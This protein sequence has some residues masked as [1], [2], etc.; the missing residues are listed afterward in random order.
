MGRNVGQGTTRTGIL[1]AL[2]CYAMWGVLPL[3]WKLLSG[4][5]SLEVVS[6]RIIWCCAFTII[7]C[8][9]LKYDFVSL[10]KERRAR[11][12]LI[13]AAILI[14]LNWSI[15]II[16]V[17]TDHIVETA[18]GYY[19]NPLVSIVLGVIVFRERLSPLQIVAV[20]LCT[21]GII[22]FTVGYGQMPLIA[23]ALA[24]T[25]GVYGA[26]KKKGGYPAVEALAF[27]NLVV[28]IPA[29]LVAIGTAFV[30]G[31]HGFLG[32]VASLEGCKITLLLVLG[33][34]VT[35]L[36]LILFALA[37]NLVPLSILGFIQ[38]LS[39]TLALLI[40][41]FVN[42]EPFTM[43]HAVCLGC[44]WSGLALVLIDTGLRARKLRHHG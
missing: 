17:E 8:V 37:A 33:G 27:E 11:R 40:G 20:V 14:T 43:T 31:D 44:I 42:G 12:Y 32:D 10:L 38:F 35:A 9:L 39:P 41:V 6:H 25:F 16:A 1:A 13:P 3:F 36:P 7:A 26:I 29:I 34:V 2:G 21:L 15:Y 22:A 4:V 5:N 28:L 23:V 19:L 18:I 30:V 24:L